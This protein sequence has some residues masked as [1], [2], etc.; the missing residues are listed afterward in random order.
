MSSAWRIASGKPVALNFTFQR[1]T[2]VD[3]IR[4]IAAHPRLYR[5]LHDD[6]APP[7]DEWT[8]IVHELVSYMVAYKDG[9]P[10]GLFIVSAHSPVLWEIHECFLPE[11]WGEQSISATIQFR[12]WIWKESACQRLFGQIVESNRLALRFAKAAGM[13]QFGMHPKSFMKHGRM[14]DQI[15]VGLSRPEAY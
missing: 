3:L 9:K 14:Q 11:A 13:S 4:S 8:P 10:I 7:R 5:H 1:T 6:F 12:E 15:L 2:D